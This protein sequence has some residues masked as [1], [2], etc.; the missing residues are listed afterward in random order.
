[1]PF[2]RTHSTYLWNPN[3]KHTKDQNHLRASPKKQIGAQLMMAP[4]L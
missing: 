2:Q 3:T 1:V 4:Y